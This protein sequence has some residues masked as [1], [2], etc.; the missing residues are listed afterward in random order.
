MIQVTEATYLRIRDSFEMEK[1]GV[2]DIKGRGG[3]ATF[4]LKGGADHV[5][6]DGRGRDR[7]QTS[8]EPSFSNFPCTEALDS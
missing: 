5:T 4:L 6:S 3:M 2:I 8:K 7:I 1:R